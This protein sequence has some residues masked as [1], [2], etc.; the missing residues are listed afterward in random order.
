MTAAPSVADG[1]W[2]ALAWSLAAAALL[3]WPAGACSRRARVRRVAGR[4]RA[5]R[6]PPRLGLLAGGA[7]GMAAVAVAGLAAAPLAILA[8]P[9]VARLV[10]RFGERAPPRTADPSLPLALDLMAAALRSGRPLSIAVRLAAPA[11]G[12]A[13][14]AALARVAG[15]LD[16]GADPAAAWALVDESALLPVA[17]AA[18][19]SADSGARL[20]QGFEQLAAD[21]RQQARTA[22]QEGAQ[23][24]GVLAMLPL[25][26]C[27]LPAF[28][29]IGVVPVVVSIASGAFAG[30][31]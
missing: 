28:I 7:V 10:R 19:R 17:V 11:A 31:R 29:C 6:R 8:V 1:P 26:L 27:F 12:P 13:S 20:A 25:G 18:R 15:L 30:L 23:R 22:A 4:R 2:V 16:L 21:L 3:A 14:A 5:A 24:A 9:V